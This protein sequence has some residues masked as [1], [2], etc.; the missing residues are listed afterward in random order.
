MNIGSAPENAFVA[1]NRASDTWIGARDA[2]IEGLWRW[3]NNG[4]RSGAAPAAGARSSRSTRTGATTSRTSTR[5]R[6]LRRDLHRRHLERRELHGTRGFVCERMPDECPSSS[7]KVDPGQCGCAT[8]DADADSDGFA[9]C[10]ETC[11]SGSEQAGAGRLR[12]RR[13]PKPTTTTTARP[14]CRDDCP[15]DP[16]QT[17]ACLTFVPTNFNPDPINFAAQ[18]SSTLNCGTTTVNTTDPDGTGP[19]VATISNWCGGAP[20]P[21][22]QAQ[23]QAGGPEAV[24]IALRGLTVAEREHVAFDRQPAGDPRRRRNRVDRGHDRRGRERLDPG[25]GR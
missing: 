19:M 13:R 25:R 14:N 23:T 12:L 21:I 1:M 16:T 22:A 7:S 17:A 8:A 20:V 4:V 18:P 6:G 3:E 11:D 15:G 24:I 2:T 10:N 5:R 9:D